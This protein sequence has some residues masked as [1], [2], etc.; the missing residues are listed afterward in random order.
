[1]SSDWNRKR[2]CAVC[3]ET[4]TTHPYYVGIN[5]CCS[6]ACQRNLQA[7]AKLNGGTVISAEAFADE[8]EQAAKLKAEAAAR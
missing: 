2:Q 3:G 5:E 6:T 8:M 1:M 7:A 4:F